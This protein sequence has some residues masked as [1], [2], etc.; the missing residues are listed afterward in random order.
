MEKI[1]EL[2][3]K[4][5]ILGIL[6]LAI[7]FVFVLGIV[8]FFKTGKINFGQFFVFFILIIIL[9]SMVFAPIIDRMD[10][11]YDWLIKQEELKNYILEKYNLSKENYIEV[12]K[13]NIMESDSSKSKMLKK[14]QARFYARFISE[15]EIEVVV[16]DLDGDYL[17]EPERIKNFIYFKNNYEPKEKE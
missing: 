2:K 14:Y 4:R 16:K 7:S 17:E 3:R 11:E 8:I 10:S 13:K 12:I 15:D 1:Q 9:L 5:N 6:F